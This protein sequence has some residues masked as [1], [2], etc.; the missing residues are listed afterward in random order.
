MVNIFRS[1][2]ISK[3]LRVYEAMYH[4]LDSLRL[5]VLLGQKEGETAT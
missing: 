2:V 3:S 4:A 5:R 1:I